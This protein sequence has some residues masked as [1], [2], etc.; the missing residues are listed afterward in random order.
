[1]SIFNSSPS[2]FLFQFL[3]FS[4]S[5]FF[6]FLLFY[7]F[8][9]FYFFQFFLSFYFFYFF[10]LFTFLIFS[11]LSRTVTFGFSEITS[12]LHVYL[13]VCP[14]AFY[15]SFF[16][17]H[18]LLIIRPVHFLDGKILVVKS[19]LWGG[20]GLDKQLSLFLHFISVLLGFQKNS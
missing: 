16:S 6:L 12:C 2:H 13:S 17:P 14:T 8:L 10:S 11:L 20:G 5:V 1:M 9:S 15:L 7:F 19:E 18:L 4:F 3:F